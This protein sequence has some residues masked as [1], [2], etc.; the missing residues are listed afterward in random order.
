MR[1]QHGASRPSVLHVPLQRGLGL[2]E[3]V[4]R[5]LRR[6][7]DV[8]LV[9]NVVRLLRHGGDEE[10]AVPRPVRAA[11]RVE[12]VVL[13][14]LGVGLRSVLV[15]NAQAVAVLRAVVVLQGE[16]LTT[17]RC[18]S[19][20][21]ERR[22]CVIAQS[23]ALGPRIDC[24]Q[25]VLHRVGPLDKVAT[26]AA[27]DLLV[28]HPANGDVFD[29]LHDVGG[30][31]VD[32]ADASLV[33]AA[34]LHRGRLSGVHLLR[35]GEVVGVPRRHAVAPK[36][37]AIRVVED[38][39]RVRLAALAGG[40][41][42]P[43]L[44]NG[45]R[46]VVPRHDAVVVDNVL[47]DLNAVGAVNDEAVDA[48]AVASVLVHLHLAMQVRVLVPGDIDAHAVDDVVLGLLAIAALPRA[49]IDEPLLARRIA[50]A[51]LATDGGVVP[52]VIPVVVGDLVHV[53]VD[54]VAD[55][56]HLQVGLRVD[57]LG[58]RQ[59]HG[60]LGGRGPP[61]VAV[62]FVVGDGHVVA[63]VDTNAGGGAMVHQQV[64]DE[65]VVPRPDGHTAAR[66]VLVAPQT[67]LHGLGVVDAR[68]GAG[69]L[70]ARDLDVLHGLGGGAADEAAGAGELDQG[71]RAAAITRNDEVRDAG[72][73][74]HSTRP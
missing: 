38:Q 17:A 29:R 64:V 9:E 1:R 74:H 5:R 49:T 50:A 48:I 61:T 53:V 45:L 35:E 28:L 67:R 8:G 23:L 12:G 6:G 33:V 2:V 68:A 58:G 32:L 62:D 13:A 20:I 44:H 63:L 54:D 60:A 39:A 52:S 37:D 24:R 15:E 51:I 3:N 71:P 70:E 66:V 21:C 19:R 11:V 18:G 42:V 43:V 26:A 56:A 69:D 16:G 59:D 10:Q 27:C 31:D 65:D 7:G 55:E 22:G 34:L 14:L 25:A 73:V 36:G 30:D 46:L 41:R 57:A 72:Q 40:G 47:L 4:V